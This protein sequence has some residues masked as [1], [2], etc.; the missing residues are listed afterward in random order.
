M[1]SWIDRTVRTRDGRRF[2]V[3]AC[4]AIWACEPSELSL[5]H[6]LFYVKAAG[7]LA[8]VT[9]FEGGAQQDRLAG[10]AYGLAVRI[11]ERLEGAIRLNTPV[12]RIEQDDSGVTVT[13]EDGTAW[14]A[15]HAVVAVP[16][17]SRPGSPT[18]RRCRRRV[19]TCCNGS[20]WAA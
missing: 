2:L 10:G 19:T 6:A 9:D 1:R 17:R 16:P 13:A 15:R 5:L 12:R 7:G 11:A 3:L 18:G 20:P 14:R 8:A 4:R